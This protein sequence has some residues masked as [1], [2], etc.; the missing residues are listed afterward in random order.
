MVTGVIKV[1]GSEGPDLRLIIDADEQRGYEIVGD[2]AQQIWKL[3]Q[4]QVTVR[5]WVVEEAQLP[6]IL[7]RLNVVAIE[8]EAS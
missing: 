1:T 3:Q 8:D 5:G 7:A 2:L 4:K 6:G